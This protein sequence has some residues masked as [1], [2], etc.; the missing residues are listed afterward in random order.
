MARPDARPDWPAISIALALVGAVLMPSGASA[1]EDATLVLPETTIGAVTADLD[2]DGER[3]IIR[4]IEDDGGSA[5]AV[6]AWSHD[7]RA[8]S[9]HG[10]TPIPPPTPL[11]EPSTAGG[12]G[13]V[14]LLPLTV[15]GRDRVLAFSAVLDRND[16]NGATCCLTLS[17]VRLSA[18]GRLELA[19][20]QRID[21]AAQS[22]HAADVDGDGTDELVLQAFRFGIGDEE[23]TVTVLRWVDSGFEPIFEE[24]DARWLQGFT[25]AES[26]GVAGDDFVL[27]PT[28]DG[29]LRRV[30][31]ADG[32]LQADEARVDLGGPDGAWVAGVADGTIL[33]S[34]VNE[35]RAVRWP[36]G[37]D[38]V[39]V[40]SLPMRTYSGMYLLGDG[41]DALVAL[42]DGFLFEGGDDPTVSLHDLDLEPLGEVSV[43]PATEQFWSIA[44]GRAGQA[45][46]TLSRNLHPYTGP[47]EGVRLDDRPAFVASGMLVQ[48]GGPDGYEARP[49]ASLI[50]MMPIGSAGPDDSWVVLSDTFGVASGSA[51]LIWGGVPFGS[52]RLSVAPVDQLLR[53]D[54]EAL[55]VSYELQNA[56]EIAGPGSGASLLA[57]G[58]GFGVAVTAPARST[59]LVANDRSVTEHTVADEPLVVDIVPR[60]TRKDKQGEDQEFEAT[61]VVIGPDGR[62]TTAEWRGTFVRELPEI[63]VAGTTDALALSA[64]LEGRATPGSQVLAN[65][66]LIPTG[67]DGRFEATVDAPIWPSQVT[68]IARDPLGNTATELVEVVGVADYRGLPWTSM[69]VAATIIVGVVLYVRTPKRRADPSTPDG[70]GRLEELELDAIDGI[71]TGGR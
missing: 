4:I 52:G 13:A 39:T 11:D 58:E 48:A 29:S 38:L 66:G 44:T 23:S 62:G 1:A 3:E 64:T 68:V 2:G 9:S 30:A 63:T 37:E 47:L 22:F 50:G 8:W 18:G 35:T 60:S 49:M 69:V 51:Y 27:A 41:P 61:I 34:L 31:W 33:L 65:G 20:I 10:S 12:P 43:N 24:T 45:W 56:V 70:D 5:H 21:S 67:A 59:V 32:K 28:T 54:D 19:L 53:P 7:G 26:D 25:L 16:P 71:E 46:N 40:S 14:A 55:S 6:D 15:A 36:R 17:E 42:Q 57:D